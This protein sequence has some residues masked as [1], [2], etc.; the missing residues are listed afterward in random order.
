MSTEAIFSYRGSQPKLGGN[1]S[2]LPQLFSLLQDRD[3]IPFISLEGEQA[4]QE[5]GINVHEMRVDASIVAAEGLLQYGQAGTLINRLNRTLDYDRLPPS[6]ELPSMINE[7]ASRDITNEKHAVYERVLRPFNIGIATMLLTP[8]VD[9]GQFIDENMSEFYMLKPNRGSGGKG[10]ET[11]AR[12]DLLRI[13]AAG[14]DGSM[15]IQPMYDFT[16][17]LPAGL[18][19]YDAASTDLFEDVKGSSASKELRVY[20]FHNAERTDVFAVGRAIT[21]GTDDWFFIDPDTVEPDVFLKTQE[22]IRHTAHLTGALKMY[23]ALDF[24]YG[25]LAGDENK[26]HAIELNSKQPYLIGYDKHAGVAHRL[27]SLF[28]DQISSPIA[29]ENLKA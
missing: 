20:G 29:E 7:N 6:V 9:V 1:L 18:K 26:W 5:E 22:A 4:F 24:G 27:R 16:G 2:G 15:I 3:V 8:D 23:G 19:Q 11:I 25:G 13:E 17:R 10:L 12:D 21:E 14:F 28:A